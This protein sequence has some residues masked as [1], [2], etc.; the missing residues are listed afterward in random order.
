[1]SMSAREKRALKE[2]ESRLT[3]EDRDLAVTLKRR[4]RWLNDS[5]PLLATAG[6]VVGV[7]LMALGMVQA[8]LGGIAVA[9]AGYLVLLGSTVAGVDLLRRHWHRTG[10]PFHRTAR[11]PRVP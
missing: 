10:L 9:L 3:A 7:I 11:E 5:R 8:H 6:L 4:R 2:I 1:M